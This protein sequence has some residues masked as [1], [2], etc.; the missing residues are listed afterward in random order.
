MSLD[1]LSLADFQAAVGTTF[2]SIALD[3]TSYSLTLTEAEGLSE[4]PR[5]APGFSLLFREAGQD[6]VPQQIHTLYGDAVGALDLFLVPV[7]QDEQG[8]VY[9]AVITRAQA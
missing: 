9:E 7:A 3:G 8:T 4:H 5:A 1:D 2:T 6:V